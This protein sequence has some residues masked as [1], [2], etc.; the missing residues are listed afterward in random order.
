MYRSLWNWDKVKDTLKGLSGR[1]GFPPSDSLNFLG[2]KLLLHNGKL[3]DEL[4]N[5]E[6]PDI[7]PAV[8]YV[9]HEY[10]KAQEKPETGEI[11]SFKMLPG[12]QQYYGSFHQRVIVRLEK[13]YAEN[14]KLFMEASQILGGIKMDIGDYSIKI[15]SLP[16]FPI[17]FAF[18]LG[19]EEL[20]P[21]AGVFFDSSAPNYL[22]AEEATILCEIT[23]KRIGDVINSLK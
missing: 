13:R 23:L 15:Y 18:W 9:L 3:Y 1:L 17:I 6:Y 7:E 8:Y 16:R 21:S 20:P 11:I 22:T 19:D 12:G 10:A 4:R 14:I 5:Q 2:L